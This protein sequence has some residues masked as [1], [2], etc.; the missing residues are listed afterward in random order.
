[1]KFGEGEVVSLEIWVKN[2][3]TRMNSFDKIISFHLSFMVFNDSKRSIKNKSCIC[4]FQIDAPLESL[5]TIF[6]I[7]RQGKRVRKTFFFLE[8]GGRE[9]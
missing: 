9:R 6:H 5:K 2:N 4:H 3:F 7:K 1:M 8:G